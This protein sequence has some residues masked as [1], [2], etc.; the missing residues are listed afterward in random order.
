VKH[1]IKLKDNIPFK[2]P[3]RRIAPGIIEEVRQDLKEMLE[4]GAIRK[5]QSPYC[6]NV[7]LARKCKTN[8]LPILIHQMRISTNQVSSVMLRSKK[9]KCETVKEQSDENQK[10]SAMRLSQICGRIELCLREII[11]RIEMNL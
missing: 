6:S 8:T 4:A 7:V 3:Y 11:L 1:E 10:Q 9:L 2:E 5:S